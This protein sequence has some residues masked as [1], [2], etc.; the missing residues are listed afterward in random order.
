MPSKLDKP[1]STQPH[2]VC[3]DLPGEAVQCWTSRDHI[4]VVLR[5]HRDVIFDLHLDKGKIY[6][7]QSTHSDYYNARD[8][9]LVQVQRKGIVT[10]KDGER[11][12]VW[13]T[14][15]FQG[16]LF[17]KDGEKII[18]KIEPNEVDRHQYGNDPKTKPA[19]IIISMGAFPAPTNSQAIPGTTPIPALKTKNISN[20]TTT[21]K[22]S[23]GVSP[24]L[25]TPSAAPID[26]DCSAVCVVDG[27][28]IS[29]M[30]ERIFQHYKKGGGKTGIADIDP[31]EIT[32]RNWIY[33][34]LA[35][36]AAYA[37]DN[38]SWLRASLDRQAN[39]RFKLVTAKIH[40]INGKVRFY[41]SGFSSSNLI[42][43]HGAH[44]PGHER[45]L[46]IFSGFGSTS[47][48]FKAVRNAVFGTFKANAAVS[49]I[50]G[51]AT[52]IAEWKDDIKKDEYDL[53]AGIFTA[54]VKSIIVAALVVLVVSLI[55]MFVMALGAA[56]LSV[57][58]VGALTVALGVGLGYLVEATDKLVGR[59]ATRDKK[60]TE[61]TAG[62][63]APFLRK[64]GKQIQ[65]SW[66]YLVEK[67]PSDYPV[68][69]F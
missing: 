1:S 53:A 3:I 22:N 63:I 60:N 65:E 62:I 38:W 55:V 51:T 17:V 37:A 27:G 59:T 19:P 21:L 64:A 39:Q 6:T 67:Y 7:L 43:G 18:V 31:F 61:G 49:F 12:H 9:K 36:T 20:I 30:P 56:A 8:K 34:Q 68:V 13:V 45:I 66:N 50:F 69:E 58:V 32:T 52:A 14:R 28:D 40:V 35:G 48:T 26:E 33:G 15:G 2:E 41:F 42:F 16:A 10:F 54:V 24:T 47:T 23:V 57:L 25:S 4:R 46:T 5:K 29:N 44:G 11:F